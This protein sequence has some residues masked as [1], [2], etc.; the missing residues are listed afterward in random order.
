MPFRLAG[1]PERL[2]EERQPE[3][4]YLASALARSI[5]ARSRRKAS[6]SE[7]ASRI[8]WPG[9]HRDVPPRKAERDPFDRNAA[10]GQHLPI[11]QCP[12]VLHAHITR[13]EGFRI[14]SFSKNFTSG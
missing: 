5:R 1:A 8:E 12:S 13:S 14:S 7:G 10:S 2:P 9:R 4:S 6:T 3:A 11:I